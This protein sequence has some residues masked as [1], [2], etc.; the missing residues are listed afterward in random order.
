[1]FDVWAIICND[2]VHSGVEL[3]DAVNQHSQFVIAYEGFS[4]DGDQGTDVVGSLGETKQES[5]QEGS[6]G[7][8]FGRMSKK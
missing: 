1:M 8:G 3:A 7:G 4:S 2:D 6:A 5:W